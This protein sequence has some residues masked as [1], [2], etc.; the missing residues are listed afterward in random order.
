MSILESIPDIRRVIG[1]K[2]FKPEEYRIQIKSQIRIPEFDD[3]YTVAHGP[4]IK[5]VNF[6]NFFS[7]LSSGECKVYDIVLT[8]H[9]DRLANLSK[10]IIAWCEVFDRCMRIYYKLIERQTRNTKSR[11]EELFYVVSH[12]IYFLM[13]NSDGQTKREVLE[14][15]PDFFTTLYS[16]VVE[17]IILVNRLDNI[18]TALNEQWICTLNKPRVQIIDMKSFKEDD[19]A[20]EYLDTNDFINT[21]PF[22]FRQELERRIDEERTE[23]EENLIL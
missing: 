21:I 8:E 7:Y 17:N 13:R 15:F 5:R 22:S 14:K 2:L 18:Q 4:F 16:E 10:E 3:K 11:F 6:D 19:Q 20:D 23:E 9:G 12:K 1:E